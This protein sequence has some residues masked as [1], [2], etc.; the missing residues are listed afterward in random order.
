MVLLDTDDLLL[1]P[2]DR[3]LTSL[4]LFPIRGLVVRRAGCM[5]ISLG[6]DGCGDVE[7]L[8]ATMAGAA[9]MGLH[10]GIGASAPSICLN[11]LP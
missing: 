3:D 6:L 2:L 9:R 11:L 1:S 10:A 7:Y 4:L 5:A 8:V